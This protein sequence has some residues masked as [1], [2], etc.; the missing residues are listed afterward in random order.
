MI[1]YSDEE[2]FIKP[3]GIKNNNGIRDTSIK[4][5]HIAVGVFS[6]YLLKDVVKKFECQKVGELTG[7]RPVYELEYKNIKIT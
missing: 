7:K 3:R 5:P 2:G 1:I 6:E 4:L